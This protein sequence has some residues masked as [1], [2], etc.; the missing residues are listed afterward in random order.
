MFYEI[1]FFILLGFRY[2]GISIYAIYI[3]YNTNPPGV[4]FVGNP[5]HVLLNYN[6][7]IS[8]GIRLANPL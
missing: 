5:F 2:P 6:I 7:M 3:L 4:C 1:V 8:I